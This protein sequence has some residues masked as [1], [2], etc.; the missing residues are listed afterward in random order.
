VSTNCVAELQN[1]VVP[2]TYE[3][4]R[5]NLSKTDETCLNASNGTISV[6]NQTGGRSPYVFTIVAPSPAGVGTSNS[7]GVF[8]GLPGGEYAIEL[9]DSCGGIQTRRVNVL[10]YDWWIEQ[11]IGA[12]VNCRDANF[13]LRLR[14]SRGNANTNTAVFASFQYGV[15]NSPGDTS[16]F[17]NYQFTYDLES[18]RGVRLVAKDNCGNVRG[19]NWSDNSIPAVANVVATSFQSCNSFTATIT[20]QVNLTNPTY[21]LLNSSNVQVACN[22]TGIFPGIQEGTYSI[23][24]RDDCFDTTITRNFVLAQP[25]L[26]LNPNVSLNRVSCDQVSASVSGL[27][28]FTTSL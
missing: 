18:R 17:T 20:G 24:V 27:V 23:T 4:P 15:V 2:G 22:N 28:N 5:F 19:V 11:H 6:N 3:D 1:I 7:T 12:R 9:K 21:C 26:S 16:W 8:T 25:S 10:A 13:E 14:D